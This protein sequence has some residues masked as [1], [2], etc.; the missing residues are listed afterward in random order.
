MSTPHHHAL[1]TQARGLLD[2]ARRYFTSG[3][4]IPGRDYLTAG[5]DLLM[6]LAG[7]TSGREGEADPDP[8]WRKFFV[9][10]AVPYLDS[11]YF[12]AQC[13]EATRQEEVRRK[14]GEEERRLAAARNAELE[15]L[16]VEQEKRDE[17]A[18]QQQREADAAARRAAE[19]TAAADEARRREEARQAAEQYEAQQRA[20]REWEEHYAQQVNAAAAAAAASAA[21]AAQRTHASLHA[22]AVRGARA[23]V[24]AEQA[25]A[26][27][28]EARARAAEAQANLAALARAGAES[29]RA[30]AQGELGEAQRKLAEA[31]SQRAAMAQR[32]Q[33]ANAEAEELR[34][35]LGM[36]LSA[37]EAGVAAELASLRQKK[38]E[39]EQALAASQAQVA[40]LRGAAAAAAATGGSGSSRSEPQQ[41]HQQPQPQHQHQQRAAPSAAAMA[42]MREDAKLAISK[43]RADKAAAAAA[44]SAAAVA[45]PAATPLR[46]AHGGA[47]ARGRSPAAA[48]VVSRPTYAESLQGQKGITPDDIKYVEQLERTVVSSGLN[49]A[50][51]DI[52]GLEEA[53]RKLQECMQPMT[54]PRL[55]KPLGELEPW[56]GALLYGPPGTGK[57]MLARAMATQCGATFINVE[58]QTLQ[59]QWV[60]AAPKLVGHL[61]GMARFYAPSIVFLDEIDGIARDRCV[62]AGA[63][64]RRQA[65]TACPLLPPPTASFP[66]FF[67]AL[68]QRTPITPTPAAP[69]FRLT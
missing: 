61:F 3:A 2:E 40:S 48:A 62:N 69:S 11:P 55:F 15:R 46:A 60:G 29:A 43:A 49:V 57:T 54:L 19:A 17:I 41:P 7:R 53:K 12:S 68:T 63:E 10:Q 21:D 34:V 37:A 31:T 35:S 47:K 24:S 26:R 44:T 5:L 59:S 23:E 14:L 22:A 58:P 32:L 8:Q 16:R 1:F 65:P 20:Q 66:S 33:D 25:A 50:W 51:G 13:S 39:L 36:R 28:A 6:L 27:E 4:L 38:L 42:Q 56:T 67:F 64:L 9:E 30:K 18:R 45:A 52:A